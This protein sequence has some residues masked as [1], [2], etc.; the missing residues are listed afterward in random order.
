[1]FCIQSNF[2]I[3]RVVGEFCRLAGVFTFLLVISADFL[4][5]ECICNN[6]GCYVIVSIFGK[7]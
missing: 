3:A 5:S 4:P 7:Y 2:I 1:M 6:V